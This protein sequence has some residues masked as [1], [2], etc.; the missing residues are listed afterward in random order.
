[1]EAAYND[2][3]GVTA[4]FNLNMLQVLNRELSANFD[5]DNFMHVAFFDE[6]NQWIEMRLRA[7]KACS[8]N[9]QDL[10]LQV[11][12]AEG[13][14]VR[15]EISAKFTKQRLEEEYQQA[16]LELCGWFT[17]NENLFAVSLARLSR[18]SSS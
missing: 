17:D 15:T 13:E 8:I 3:A 11:D 9:F 4:Q 10:K 2:K 18:N 7:K 5:L 12:F 14:E 16:G 6:V 1:M